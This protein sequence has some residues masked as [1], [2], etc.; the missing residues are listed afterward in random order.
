MG[1]V[2]VKELNK[3]SIGQNMEYSGAISMRKCSESDAVYVCI[4]DECY[5]V[6]KDGIEEG[7]QFKGKVY[8]FGSNPRIIDGRFVAFKLKIRQHNVLY[9]AITSKG[10]KQNP[11]K[12]IL[13][14]QSLQ[15]DDNYK[16]VNFCYNPVKSKDGRGYDGTIGSIST[17]VYNT[18]VNKVR[19][20]DRPLPKTDY[21]KKAIK[22]KKEIED[23]QYIPF[24]YEKKHEDIVLDDVFPQEMNKLYF[25]SK[26]RYIIEDYS[27]SKI[28]YSGCLKE[29]E[30]K[31]KLVKQYFKQESVMM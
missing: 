22:L 14:C 31:Y 7:N 5:K 30:R 1:Y 11:I 26:L 17:D 16:V 10:S 15:L 6:S 4:G 8:A 3:V 28:Y 27:S 18:V 12:P 19:L 13:I 25:I 29:L 21:V 20:L 9:F 23:S 2:R 24:R